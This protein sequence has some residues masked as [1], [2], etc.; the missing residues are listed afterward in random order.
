MNQNEP[1]EPV[2][3]IFNLLSKEKERNSSVIIYDA[4]GELSHDADEN[5]FEAV[6]NV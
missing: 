1:N 2:K 4:N 6:L 5:L 3:K